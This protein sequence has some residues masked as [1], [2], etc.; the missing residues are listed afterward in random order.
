[1][2]SWDGGPW[3]A[4]SRGAQFARSWHRWRL[5]GWRTLKAMRLRYGPPTDDDDFTGIVGRTKDLRTITRSTVPLLSW[6]R[7]HAKQNLLPGVDL[8]SALARFE[9]AVPARCSDRQS[10]WRGWRQHGKGSDDA[11]RES[12]AFGHRVRRAR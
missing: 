7:D 9:Y 8:S 1:M 12:L 5:P 10:A 6:W 3:R 2:T 11:T 4:T